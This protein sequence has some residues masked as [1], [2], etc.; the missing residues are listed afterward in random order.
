MRNSPFSVL[1]FLPSLEA[2]DYLNSSLMS[3]LCRFMTLQSSI[4]PSKLWFLHLLKDTIVAYTVCVS[5]K[6][7]I[8]II[9]LDDLWNIS[10]ALRNPFACLYLKGSG[11]H[12]YFLRGTSEVTQLY[13]SLCDPMDCSLPGFSIHGIF[14]ARVL[15]W[16]AIAFSA[17][18]P[19]TDAK[20]SQVSCHFHFLL[21]MKS[22]LSFSLRFIQKTISE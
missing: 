21:L 9:I 20:G 1:K 6:Q 7:I 4:N 10:S 3:S 14:Q 11:S 5:P 8:I 19:C 13:P 15:E 22:L 2:S 16:G 17:P 18:Q 12:L